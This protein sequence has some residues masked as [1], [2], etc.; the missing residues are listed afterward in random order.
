MM[1]KRIL[2]GIAAASMILTAFPAAALTVS[3]SG[4]A[5]T[6]ARMRVRIERCKRFSQGDDYERCVRLIK[7]LPER[8]V[9]ND[10][11]IETEVE[12]TAETDMDWKWTNILNRI[13]AKLKSSVKFV[14]VMAKNFCKDRTNDNATTSRECMT[15]LKTEL[16]VRVAAL[17]D[18]AFRTDT[19]K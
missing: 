10:M 17:I 9:Q 4:S 12:A 7:R 5:T 18:A 2:S 19:L 16:Q 1:T 3:G 13:E 14:S 8:E 6:D 15:R 11:E